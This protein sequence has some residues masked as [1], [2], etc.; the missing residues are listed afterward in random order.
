MMKHIMPKRTV[1]K[2]QIYGDNKSKWADKLLQH[3][4]SEVLP[5]RY[6]GTNE[7]FERVVYYTIH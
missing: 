4:S 3:I 5:P 2:Y 7:E 1:E 6:G